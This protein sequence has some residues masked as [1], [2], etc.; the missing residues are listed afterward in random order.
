MKLDVGKIAFDD[1]PIG[2]EIVDRAFEHQPAAIHHRDPFGGTF[3]L[4]DLVRRKDHGCPR[5]ASLMIRLN[6]WR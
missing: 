2:L 5:A 3:D 1:L 4:A 6:T